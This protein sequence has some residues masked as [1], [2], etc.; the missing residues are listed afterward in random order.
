[1]KT[2]TFVHRSILPGTV[3][4]VAAVHAHP[5]AFTRLTMPPLIAQILR[6]TRT[7][8]T[9]GELEFRLWFGPVPVHWL[10]R[11][12]AGPTPDSFKDVQIEGPLA[13]WEHEHIFEAAEGG[14]RLTDRITFAHRPGFPGLLTRL[15]FDGLP[16][17]VLFIYRHWQTRRMLQS[18]SFSKEQ[19][20]TIKGHQ[21]GRS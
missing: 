21:G 6:D 4:E 14:T 18:G 16:L 5:K 8:L 11:H 19:V 13:R 10:A 15:L 7:S 3:S 20:R 1:M 17:R 9:A 12:A 2:R